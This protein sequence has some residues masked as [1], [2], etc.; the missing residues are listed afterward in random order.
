MVWWID[1]QERR[2]DDRRQLSGI[3]AP[4]ANEHH[5]S[6]RVSEAEHGGQTHRAARVGVRQ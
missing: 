1:E 6:L 2:G 5:E 3:A 4:L